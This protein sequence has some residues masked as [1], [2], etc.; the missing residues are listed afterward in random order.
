MSINEVNLT[1]TTLT[2]N[3]VTLAQK[4]IIFNSYN[5]DIKKY[6]SEEI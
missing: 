1:K 2:I 4:Q 3:L 6:N 5:N